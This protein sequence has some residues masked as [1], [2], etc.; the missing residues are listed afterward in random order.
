MPNEAIEAS[1]EL[2]N[3]LRV[4]KLGPTTGWTEGCY[5]DLES[6]HLETFDDNGNQ[7]TIVTKEHLVMDM[8]LV[9]DRI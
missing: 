8:L 5:G 1:R 3:E 6:V 2:A 4:Y 7:R 9:P